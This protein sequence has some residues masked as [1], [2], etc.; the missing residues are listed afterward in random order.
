MIPKMRLL[1]MLAVNTA[2]L[3]VNMER[4]LK[5]NT[6]DNNLMDSN[7]VDI[8]LKVVNM[9]NSLNMDISRAILPSREVIRHSKQAIHH[10]KADIQGS[11]GH[12]S[13]VT[14]SNQDL[15][16]ILASVPTKLQQL[17]GYY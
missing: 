2:V 5:V 9:D 16:V 10:S 12:P 17:L 15:E 3:L 8:H 6:E 7:K 13:K 1:V 4:H 11:N 14:V